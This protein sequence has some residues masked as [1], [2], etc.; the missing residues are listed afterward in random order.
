MVLANQ[1]AYYSGHE[2]DAV[3][4]AHKGGIKGSAYSNAV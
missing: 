4:Q 1:M 2:K 3:Q